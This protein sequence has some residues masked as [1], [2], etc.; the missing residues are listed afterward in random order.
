MTDSPTTPSIISLTWSWKI[1]RLFLR[2]LLKQYFW[3]FLLKLLRHILWEVLKKIFVN[4]G[5]NFIE[6]FSAAALEYIISL[7]R[8]H[9]FFRNTFAKSYSNSVGNSFGNFYLIIKIKECL[10]EFLWKLIQ[11]FHIKILSAILLEIAIP[12]SI[13]W[14]SPYENWW[15]FKEIAWAFLKK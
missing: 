9:N 15:V 6:T 2:K 4:T 8:F 14:A 11:R 13:L 12:L 5:W 1:V 3:E 10:R 7:E